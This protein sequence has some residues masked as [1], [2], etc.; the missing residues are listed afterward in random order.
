M[1]EK[2]YGSTSK[3]RIADIVG[4]GRGWP[5]GDSRRDLLDTLWKKIGD[6]ANA[7]H[8]PEGDVNAEIFNADD[9]RLVLMLTATL[10]SYV[11]PA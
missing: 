4:D 2:H 6:V 11:R 9:A 1:W 5:A 10:S 3:R 7:P 8:H